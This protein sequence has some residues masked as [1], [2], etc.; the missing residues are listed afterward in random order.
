[1]RGVWTAVSPQP[2]N[3]PTEVL[4][5]AVRLADRYITGRFLPEGFAVCFH[6]A[7]LPGITYSDSSASAAAPMMPASLPSVAGICFMSPSKAMPKP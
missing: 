5:A 1:M 7:A 2:S 3:N 6:L 4:E